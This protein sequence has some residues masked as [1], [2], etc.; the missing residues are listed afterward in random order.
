MS[1]RR[2]DDALTLLLMIGSDT[3]GDIQI[4]P[5]GADPSLAPPA[6][7]AIDLGS[8]RFADLLAEAGFVDRRGIP[9]VQD[10][11]S[12]GMITL[13]ARVGGVRRSSSSI[14]PTTPTSW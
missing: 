6:L 9:G 4:L 14:R 8:V 3:I 11:V 2:A 13:P 1:Q 7:E 5:E 12:A 10:K